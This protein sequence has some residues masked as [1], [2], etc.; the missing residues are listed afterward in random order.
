MDGLF[1]PLSF[2]DGAMLRWSI[3]QGSKDEKLRSRTLA[4]EINIV[5]D[6]AQNCPHVNT[7]DEAVL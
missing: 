4:P 1:E 3:P 7:S 5:A 6:F 2:F